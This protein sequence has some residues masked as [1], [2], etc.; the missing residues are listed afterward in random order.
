M[1]LAVVLAGAA[2]PVI[3]SAAGM[4]VHLPAVVG[5]LMGFIVFIIALVMLRRGVVRLRQ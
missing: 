2:V 3:G 1:I 4:D 5:T